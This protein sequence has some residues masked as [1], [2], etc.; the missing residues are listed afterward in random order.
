MASLRIMLLVA[1]ALAPLRA[2]GAFIEY[3]MTGTLFASRVIPY[4]DGAVAFVDSSP[5]LRFAGTSLGSM[6]YT[7]SFRMTWLFDTLN[8]EVVTPSTSNSERALFEGQ[9]FE[10]VTIV[11]GNESSPLLLA[12]LPGNGPY[13]NS[14]TV[15]NDTDFIRSDSYALASN[16]LSNYQLAEIDGDFQVAV[17]TAF[18]YDQLQFT[19]PQTPDLP[20]T[21][22]LSFYQPNLADFA[23]GL[24][25]MGLSVRNRNT[26]FVSTIRGEIEHTVVRTVPEPASIALFFLTAGVVSSRRRRTGSLRVE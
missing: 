23:G 25:S 1:F 20:W 10:A 9:F 2:S 13:F 15:E 6:T 21:T 8:P 16:I 5:L 26:G 14:T 4:S 22:D 7:E 18:Y 12:N 17:V 3:E 19:P 24:R 11:L